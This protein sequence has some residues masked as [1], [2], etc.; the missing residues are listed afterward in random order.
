VRENNRLA[1]GRVFAKVSPGVADGFRLDEYGN[2]WTSAEDG[3]HCVT[4][5]GELLGKIHL[6]EIISNVTFGGIRKNRLF[7]TGAN[8][9]FSVYLNCRGVQAP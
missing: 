5:Q 8:S 4:P 2:V 3:V 9:L 7:A 6:P 1:E